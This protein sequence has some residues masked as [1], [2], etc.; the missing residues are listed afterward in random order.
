MNMF[1]KKAMPQ[2]TLEAKN[3]PA[4]ATKACKITGR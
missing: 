1:L 2:E 4:K 3:F